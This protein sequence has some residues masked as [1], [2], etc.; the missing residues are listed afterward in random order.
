[1]AKPNIVREII[2][3]QCLRNMER[4]SLGVIPAAAPVGIAALAAIALGSPAVSFCPA[5]VI[6]Y[7]N[8]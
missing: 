5:S 3:N 4:T 1:M 7:P 6:N 2:I 8:I